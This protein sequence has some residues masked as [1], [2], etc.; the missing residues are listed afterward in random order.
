MALLLQL[1]NRRAFDRA[2][3]GNW[4]NIAPRSKERRVSFEQ[5]GKFGRE[6]PP[7]ILLIRASSWI[8][9]HRA[10]ILREA[11]IDFSREDQQRSREHPDRS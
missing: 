3:A 2:S 5:G 4:I 11:R 1:E 10:R 7:I 6:I 8:L 9:R